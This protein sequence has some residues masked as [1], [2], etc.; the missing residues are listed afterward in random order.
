MKLTKL[1]TDDAIALIEQGDRTIANFIE[2]LHEYDITALCYQYKSVV[3]DDFNGGIPGFLEQAVEFFNARHAD[4]CLTFEI[5]CPADHGSHDKDAMVV[6]IPK[7]TWLKYTQIQRQDTHHV[8]D[9]SLKEEAGFIDGQ[10]NFHWEHPET[11]D[12]YDVVMEV[13]PDLSADV[14]LSTATPNYGGQSGTGYV[15]IEDVKVFENKPRQLLIEVINRSTNLDEGD[16]K[17]WI[18]DWSQPRLLREFSKDWKAS[19]PSR[20]K[21]HVVMD[22]SAPGELKETPIQL[23]QSLVFDLLEN[24]EGEL[25]SIYY[26]GTEECMLSFPFSRYGDS[27]WEGLKLGIKDRFLRQDVTKSCA[28]ELSEKLLSYLRENFEVINR[29]LH[30]IHTRDRA[31]HV[32]DESILERLRAA[33][34]PV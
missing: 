29:R 28:D 23:S 20:D 7:T 31:H 5:P 19:F 14:R 32:A 1:D 3:M 22:E 18:A 30:R 2:F 15:E 13:G 16:K 25:D 17:V 27:S 8:Q 6:L 11:G 26:G 4:E 9:E 34:A 12:N 24:E 10:F 33:A 21:T